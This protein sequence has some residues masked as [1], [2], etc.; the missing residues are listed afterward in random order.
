MGANYFWSIS[1][2]DV[3]TYSVQHISQ[4]SFSCFLN[5]I[6][7]ASDADGNTLYEAFKN[8][9]DVVETLRILTKKLFEWFKDNQVNNSKDKCNL[10]LS[11]RDLKQIYIEHSF[12]KAASAK[13][14]LV[15]N[16][17]INF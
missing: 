16:L 12:S 11:K 6:D 10:T 13:K 5:E 14:S 1:R 9:D 17:I 7:I 4:W 8:V 15:L 3:R 2:F